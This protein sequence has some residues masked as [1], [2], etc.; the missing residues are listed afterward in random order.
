MSSPSSS[1]RWLLASAWALLGVALAH[2][3]FRTSEGAL[4]TGGFFNS[5]SLYLPALYRDLFEEGGRWRGW[6]L[7]PAPY[8]F[9]DMALYFLLDAL[10]GPF[11]HAAIAYAA[12]QLVALVLATQYLV[13][14]VLPREEAAVGQVVAVAVVAG[15]LLLYAEGHFWVMYLSTLSAIH[16][17]VV[18][19]SLVGLAL[20]LR[21]FRDGA[22]GALAALTLLSALATASDSLF[23]I[24]FTVPV[25]ASTALLAWRQRP[26]AWKRLGAQWGL[27]ALSIVAGLRLSKKLAGRHASAEYTRLNLE[28]IQEALHQLWATVAGQ[29]RDSPGVVL[30]WS[31]LVLAALAVVVARRKDWTAPD[32]PR[33]GLYGA[34]LFTLL[35]VGSTTSAVVLTGTFV[36]KSAIRYLVV[37]IMLPLLGVALV[38]GLPR[39]RRGATLAALVLVA[40]TAGAAVLRHPWGTE[41]PLLSRFYPDTVRCLDEHQARFGL[42]WGVGDY[43][44]AKYVSMFSRTGLRVN[45]LQSDGSLHG[46]I[47][48]RD[49][50]LDPRGEY[51]FVITHGLDMEAF[52][53]RFGPPRDTFRCDAWEVFVYGGALDGPLR[54]ELSAQLQPQKPPARAGTRAAE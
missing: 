32:S 1:T 37:P 51:T 49:W 4:G 36:D 26:H 19:L 11:V 44:Q 13:R 30:P 23:I 16:F 27:L 35:S 47:N 21:A 48:N 17:S 43:W 24:T 12:V 10:T 29:L 41:G 9:P 7:T 14:T 15:L 25:A 6:H 39:W 53:A 34:C 28:L 22:R 54:A 52:Q 2:V 46:W 18:P 31:V 40:A 38:V 5:D 20:S 50:Y 33:W 8:F 3:F 45:Q 42:K